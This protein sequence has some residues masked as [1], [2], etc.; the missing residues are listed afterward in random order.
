VISTGRFVQLGAIR[1]TQRVGAVELVVDKC[2]TMELLESQRQRSQLPR[3][4]GH[5]AKTRSGSL[6]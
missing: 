4:I 5:A 2:S 3:R 1:E 6:K